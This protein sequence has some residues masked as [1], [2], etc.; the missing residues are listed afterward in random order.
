MNRNDSAMIVP[1]ILFAVRP[2]VRRAQSGLSGKIRL[3]ESCLDDVDDVRMG[4]VETLAQQT[5]RPIER[6]AV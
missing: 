2:S 1:A 4:G 5:K 3:Q 6:R